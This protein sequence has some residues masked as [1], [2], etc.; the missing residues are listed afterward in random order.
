[1]ALLVKKDYAN[2]HVPMLPVVAGV[3]ETTYQI[4]LYSVLLI[5]LT[6]LPFTFNMLGWMYL[7]VAISLGVP[8]LYL[9]WKLWRNY[10]K[11]TSKRLYK[12]SQSYLALIFLAMVLDS[13]LF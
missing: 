5:T 6:L 3:K 2:A 13:T 10:S 8:F 9:A 1:L 4:F 12:F 11:S 7:I